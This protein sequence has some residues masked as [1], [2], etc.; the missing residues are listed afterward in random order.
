MGI[1][2]ATSSTTTK[3]HMKGFY[4]A[5]AQRATSCSSA[6]TRPGPEL[7]RLAI[8]RREIDPVALHQLLDAALND[9]S[10]P[11]WHRRL[12]CHAERIIQRHGVLEVLELRRAR[13]VG[14]RGE[15]RRL[16]NGSQQYI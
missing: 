16:H 11:A 1:I 7:A 2:R 5:P 6:S 13:R 9:H 15:Q 10:G 3:T 8:E 14:H 12:A 4:E